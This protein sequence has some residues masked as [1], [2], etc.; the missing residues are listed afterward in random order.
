MKM[1]YRVYAIIFLFLFIGTQFALG[2]EL[3]IPDDTS[4]GIWDQDSRTYTLT[5]DVNK[6]IKI[7]QDSMT[8]DGAGHK[9]DGEGT[10]YKGVDLSSKTGVV[11]K[12]LNVQG[13]DYGIAFNNSSGNALTDNNVNSSNVYGI[14]LAYDSSY[15]TIADNT[16]SESNDAGIRL[17]SYSD[18]NTLAGNSLLNNKNGILLHHSSNNNTLTG[19]TIIGNIAAPTSWHGI[20]LNNSSNNILTG[21]TTTN[22]YK[23]IV[24]S[25]SNGNTLTDNISSNNRNYGIHLNSSSHNTLT[26]NTATS[27]NGHGIYLYD[28][29]DNILESNISNN[30]LSNCSGI[31]LQESS[32]N[33]LIGNT[34]DLNSG[35]GIFLVNSSSNN[36]LTDNS[37]S[38]NKY[39]IVINHY[40][41]DNIMTGNTSALNSGY[42]IRL[43]DSSDNQVY[44]NNF[45]N[46][47]TQAYVDG[48]GGNIFNL[49]AENDGGNYWSDWTGPDIN[50]DGFV[51][52]PRVF[53]GGQDD[54][55]WVRQDAWEVDVTPEGADVVVRLEDTTTLE[56]P[57]TLV[58]DQVTE[59]GISNLTTS[60]QG[61]P[62]PSGFRLGT[63]PIYYEISTTAEFS[64]SITIFIDY[65][66]IVFG[67]EAN[68]RLMHWEDG[69]WVNVTSSLDEANDIICGTVT[70]LSQFAIFEEYHPPIVEQITAPVVPVE[71]GITISASAGFTDLGVSDT[72]TALYNWG[73]GTTSPGVVIETGV[74]WY[75][76]GN[77]A[78]T[79]AGVYTITLTVTDSISSSG[80]SVSDYVVIYDPSAGFVTGGGWIDSPSGAY[81]AAPTLAGK[82]NFGFVCKYKKGANIPIGQTEFNFRVADMNF[83]SDSY[84]WLVVAGPRA[85][86]KGDGTING[87]G[88]YG[89]MLTAID[90]NLT[91]STDVDLFRIKIWD[92]DDGDLVVYDNQTGAADDAG[93]TT[94][95]KGGNIV[96]YKEEP[97]AA[98]ASDEPISSETLLAQNYPNPFNPDTWI[99][100]RLREDANVVISI[101]SATG[102]L[103]RR[104]DLGHRNAGSYTSMEKAVHWDGRNDHGEMV[105]SGLY[106][107]TIQAGEFMDI[108]KMTIAK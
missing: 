71:V 83:H 3:L 24:L 20:S 70:T 93:P 57:V 42:G 78:Y 8:L 94:E 88:N 105:S 73:D 102:Q 74:S 31:S 61:N 4:V 49:S 98:P 75:V 87:S 37:A 28:S 77:H 45:I 26:S 81:A 30:N 91:P 43:Y 5:T 1:T 47:S 27:N 13:F 16:V 59:A 10:G 79:A 19:N 63:P 67:N 11:I 66:G 51:D 96:I 46:N 32:G 17:Y 14:Y 2:Q 39:G 53:F 6:T 12:N 18:N 72:H 33:T 65:S 9:V 103:V 41:D 95:V 84:Q 38:S 40:C 52:D 68:L 107:Y 55:P 104:L 54:A 60:G 92:K 15:N 35:Y 90:E 23:G 21:N 99:P 108:K 106:F 7:V 64:G 100:Y 82:A 50:R 58:F 69:T 86:Y 97:T 56:R 34:A 85:Q 80:E 76:N 89:F 36:T 29:S 44:N 62:L 101:Y 48:G 22:N 25:P